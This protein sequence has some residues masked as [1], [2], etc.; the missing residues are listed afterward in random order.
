[1]TVLAT[2][3][4]C[5][6]RAYSLRIISKQT[7]QT[8]T[9][10]NLEKFKLLLYCQNCPV[11]NH[12]WSVQQYSCKS[13]NLVVLPHNNNKGHGVKLRFLEKWT[14]ELYCYSNSLS[15]STIK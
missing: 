8:C 2:C 4:R 13:F 7:Y 3:T 12:M 6:F 10:S 14:F 9:R 15:C 11:F 1:M 5:S